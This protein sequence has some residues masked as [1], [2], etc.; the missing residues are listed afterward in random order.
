MSNKVPQ[1]LQDYSMF[2]SGNR[3]IGSVDITCPNIQGI[4]ASVDGAGMGGPV[5]AVVKGRFQDIV[6]TVN[7]RV[8]HLAMRD[9][10]V[11]NYQDYEFWGSIQETDS[12]TGAVTEYQ[13]KLVMRMMVKSNNIGS[14]NPGEAQ[15]RSVEFSVI[16]INEFIDGQ[17][18]QKLDKLNYIYE[19]G[20]Q[21]MLARI[22][23]NIGL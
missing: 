5:D 4:T 6:C 13:H 8:A 11:Q 19:V 14:F 1:I 22:R 21:D 10:F 2:L 9:M 12:A 3:I 15:G 7:F 23:A 20:G 17:Q 18:V 16:V